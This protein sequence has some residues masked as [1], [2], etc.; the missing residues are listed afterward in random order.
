MLIGDLGANPPTVILATPVVQVIL[1]ALDHLR[2]AKGANIQQYDVIVDCLD[3]E[4]KRQLNEVYIAKTCP[5]L[6]SFNHT[7][8][9]IAKMQL[10]LDAIRRVMKLKV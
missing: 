7:S 1:G 10:A 4:H 3:T 5:L 2:Y 9:R 8:S 6:V